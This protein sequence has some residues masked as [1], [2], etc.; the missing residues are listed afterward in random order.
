MRKSLEQNVSLRAETERQ[1]PK[2]HGR[3]GLPVPVPCVT[4]AGSS[5]LRVAKLKKGAKA[6]SVQSLSGPKLR[7]E[8]WETLG[9][10]GSSFLRKRQIRRGGDD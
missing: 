1:V 2:G 8:A 3:V 10:R 6:K 4:P 7:I 5:A 9:R